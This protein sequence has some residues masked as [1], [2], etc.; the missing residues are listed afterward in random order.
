MWEK[1]HIYIKDARSTQ[2]WD[3]NSFTQSHNVSLRKNITL[4]TATH[5]YNVK[6]QMCHITLLQ[7]HINQRDVKVKTSSMKVS[8][9]S[10]D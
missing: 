4:L 9:I 8:H 1:H 10:V 7:L 5:H 6:I 3:F 2:C